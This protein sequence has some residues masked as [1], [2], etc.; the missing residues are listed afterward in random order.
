MNNKIKRTLIISALA[1]IAALPLTACDPVETTSVKTTPVATQ[2]V[3]LTPDA[4]VPATDDNPVLDPSQTNSIDDKFYQVL[5][6]RIGTLG[7]QEQMVELA[8]VTCSEISDARE[9]GLPGNA[10]AIKLIQVIQQENPWG[11]DASDSG[12]F[13]GASVG[14]YCPNQAAYLGIE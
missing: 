13:L 2:S 11:W 12:Y 6:K 10:V 4:V 7:T 5:S 3:E 9:K 1:G 8:N 14:G